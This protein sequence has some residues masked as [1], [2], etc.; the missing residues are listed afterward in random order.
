MGNLEEVE[1]RA[2]EREAKLGESSRSYDK[3]R[4]AKREAEAKREAAEAKREAELEASMI[5]AARQAA[6]QGD[7]EVEA[8]R[9]ALIAARETMQ[10]C[11]EAMREAREILERTAYHVAS[12]RIKLI[13]GQMLADNRAIESAES[14]VIAARTARHALA[15]EAVEQIMTANR[16]VIDRREVGK[17]VVKAIGRNSVNT[18]D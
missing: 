1:R 5:E 6:K 3:H 12:Q 15:A 14:R 10:R 13:A 11:T 18:V 17:I 9:E 4:A 2:A 8:A 16:K 7:E